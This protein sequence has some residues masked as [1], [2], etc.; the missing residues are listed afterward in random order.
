MDGEESE[1]FL[2]FPS[3]NSIL[4]DLSYGVKDL[5]EGLARTIREIAQKAIMPREDRANDSAKLSDRDTKIYLKQT[6]INYLLLLIG[7]LR[8][9]MDLGS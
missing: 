1:P 2:M 7:D 8:P 4:E 5:S 6:F 3:G 9:F